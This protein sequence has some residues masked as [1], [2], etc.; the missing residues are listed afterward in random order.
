MTGT[1]EFTEHESAPSGDGDRR[2]VGLLTSPGLGERLAEDIAA[3]LPDKL[4][5]TIDS[6]KTWEVNV[7]AD[8]LTGSNVAISDVLTE[9]ARK[10]STYE[11]DYA[12]SL[13]DLPIRQDDRIIISRTGGGLDVA[14]ISIPPL[15][16]FRVRQRAL[17]MILEVMDDLSRGT[18]AVDAG[19]RFLQPSQA[20]RGYTDDSDRERNLRYTAPPIRGHIRLLAG[21][22]Y[23]NRPWRLF[24]S[25]KTT[26]ATAFATGGYGLIFTTLWEIGNAYGYARLVTLMLAAMTFLVVWIVLS[27]DLWETRDEGI[28]RYLRSLYNASTVLTIATGVVF[29]YV[30]IFLLLL[31]AAFIYIP[32]PMLESTL[33]HTVTP[34]NYVRIAWVTASVATIGGGIGAGLEDTEAV[35]NAT[36]GW[37]QSL[38]W[39]Q[40]QQEKE[41]E[42]M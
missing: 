35:R 11:W 37:R 24:P 27:H 19:A 10:K 32:M 41:D 2:M 1:Q 34:V 33:G 38:R 26:V 9:I 21:M 13:T 39:E 8:P 22:V 3:E 18:L 4:R 31:L 5:E 28:S 36:F 14:V 17:R 12:I 16:A 6:S 40:Y 30:I 23:A 20:Q 42:E 25:F 7:V 15:G 29:Y